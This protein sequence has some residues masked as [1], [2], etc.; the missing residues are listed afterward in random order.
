[1]WLFHIRW[2]RGNSNLWWIHIP[3]VDSSYVHTYLGV[4]FVTSKGHTIKKILYNN[5]NISESKLHPSKIISAYKIF[6]QPPLH[7][8]LQNRVVHK[9]YLSNKS[10]R[11]I[12]NTIGELEYDDKV[13]AL[14]KKI[15]DTDKQQSTNNSFIYSLCKLSGLGITSWYDDCQVQNVAYAFRLLTSMDGNL[16][17]FIAYDL[18]RVVKDRLHVNNNPIDTALQW[19]NYEIDS[20]MPNYSDT[21][22]YYL[23]RKC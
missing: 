13:S 12:G 6:I 15:T 14:I 17:R 18:F 3:T 19:L 8:H 20:I 11:K 23:L 4:P 5:N 21:I 22:L 9:I 2:P 16:K 10:K 7:F 1:M